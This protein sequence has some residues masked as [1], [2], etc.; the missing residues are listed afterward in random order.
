MVEAL[1][2]TTKAATPTTQ[3]SETQNKKFLAKTNLRIYGYHAT[4]MVYIWN[5]E[6]KNLLLEWITTPR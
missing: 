1:V 2:D 6:T 5:R 4:K 3:W